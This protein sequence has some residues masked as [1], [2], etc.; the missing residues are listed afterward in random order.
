MLIAHIVLVACDPKPHIHI[1]RDEMIGSFDPLSAIKIAVIVPFFVQVS[2]DWI[3]S[4][5]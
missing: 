2:T 4:S 1:R 3:M 5:E